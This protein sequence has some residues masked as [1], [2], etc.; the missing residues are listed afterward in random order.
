MITKITNVDML[1]KQGS[2]PVDDSI[3]SH[4]ITAVEGV[5][6]GYP[7]EDEP[8]KSSA[9]SPASENVAELEPVRH[10]SDTHTRTRGRTR[11]HAYA[12]AF[13]HSRAH[14]RTCAN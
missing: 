14:I 1:I 12:H 7:M 6:D 2:E 8:P 9:A 13:E 10:P 11:T 3:K 5:G 4:S